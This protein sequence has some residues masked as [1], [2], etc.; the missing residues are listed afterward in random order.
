[1]LI[2]RY[3]LILIIAIL[4]RVQRIAYASVRG[5]GMMESRSNLVLFRNHAY[6]IT[7]GAHTSKSLPN[8][9]NKWI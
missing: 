7:L 9:K 2:P 5:L 8:N 1:M 3:L 4:L 6:R